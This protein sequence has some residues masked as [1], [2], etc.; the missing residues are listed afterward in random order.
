MLG[1]RF[2]D[3]GLRLTYFDGR[4]DGFLVGFF[5]G[6]GIVGFLDGFRGEGLGV[7]FFVG[8]LLRRSEG[9]RDGFL[10]GFFSVGLEV[11]FGVTTVNT[12]EISWPDVTM[13]DIVTPVFLT[14][15]P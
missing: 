8:F 3:E 13:F 12:N 1:S 10:V 5:V 7:G 4:K 15:R 6:F 11:G 2:H 14:P 9:A